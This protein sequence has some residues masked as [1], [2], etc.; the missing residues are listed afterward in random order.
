MGPIPEAN[1]RQSQT[2]E[3]A[4]HEGSLHRTHE[5]SRPGLAGGRGAARAAGG[6]CRADG[7]ALRG[8]WRPAAA[9]ATC[10]VGARTTACCDSGPPSKPT[11]MDR[12]GSS[13]MPATPRGATA[14][15]QG[16]PF[17][18]RQGD[19]AG[20]HAPDP[21]AVRGADDEQVGSL[22]LDDS[23]QRAS[24]AGVPTT[25][26]RAEWRPTSESARSRAAWVERRCAS[27]T[28]APFSAGRY[29]Y[30]NIRTATSSPPPFGRLTPQAQRVTA[31]LTAVDADDDGLEQR[32]KCHAT[33]G[34]ARHAINGDE[35]ACSRGRVS[36]RRGQ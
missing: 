30:G 10:A 22:A 32:G 17:E 18:G 34:P 4:L 15:G 19:I 28:G 11:P 24:G 1:G 6:F 3:C 5:Q 27:T 14:T 36:R 8:R 25:C 12:C 9:H 16:G 21:G 7:E 13:P 23:V 29:W 31:A 33:V 26:V 2:P 20:Q 35:R